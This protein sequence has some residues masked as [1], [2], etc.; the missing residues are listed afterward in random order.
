M[1]TVSANQIAYLLH[2]NLTINTF[3]VLP[4]TYPVR[5]LYRK[6]EVKSLKKPNMY[7]FIIIY[8]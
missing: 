8:Q 3:Y 7:F 6:H 4:Y 2:F 5:I 1:H